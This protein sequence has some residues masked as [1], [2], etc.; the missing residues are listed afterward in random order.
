[1]RQDHLICKIYFF[2]VEWNKTKKIIGV[3][4]RKQ[5]F[6]PLNKF[7]ELK[8]YGNKTISKNDVK[9]VFIYEKQPKMVI[10]KQDFKVN[11]P[12]QIEG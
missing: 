7:I 10:V 6:S 5:L 9:K 2:D 8:N 11:T 3:V 1:M 4:E 12:T